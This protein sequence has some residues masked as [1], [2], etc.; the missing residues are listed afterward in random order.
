VVTAGGASEKLP[1]W[2][3]TSCRWNCSEHLNPGSEALDHDPAAQGKSKTA[4][5]GEERQSAILTLTLRAA[6]TLHDRH[7]LWKYVIIAVALV[8]GFLYTLPNF[9]GEVPAVQISPGKSTAKIDE[10]LRTRVE[11]ALAQANIVPD[12]VF[13]KQTASRCVWATRHPTQG[14]GR[15]AECAGENYVVGSTVVESPHWLTRINALPMYL[16]LDLRGGCTSFCRST[17]RPR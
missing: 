17:C 9:F 14:Q 15:P 12:G 10:A 6:R 2:A 8:V 11:Q 5:Q 4:G 13:S 3:I 16:G 7:P 1:G